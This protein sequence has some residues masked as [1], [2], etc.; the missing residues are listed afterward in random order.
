MS[1]YSCVSPATDAL[2]FSEVSPIGSPV[3]EVLG[4][5][6]DREP[7]RGVADLLD[8]VEVPVRVAGLALRGLAEVACDLGVALDVG[9]LREVEVAPVRLRLAR[10]GVLQVVVS[11]RALQFLGH[12]DPSPPSPYTYQ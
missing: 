8:V 6:A 11:L 4:G 9:D 2:R 7:G 12:W 3:A 10:E 5:V 1:V